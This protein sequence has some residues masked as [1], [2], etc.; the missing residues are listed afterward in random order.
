MKMSQKLFKLLITIF[1]RK[2]NK[3]KMIDAIIGKDYPKKVIP[4]IEAAKNSIKIVV[5][6]WWWYPND[7][8]NPAQIFN[9]S[10]VR[11]VRRGVEVRAIAN[12]NSFVSILNSV[13]I[14]AKKLNIKELVHAK[15]LIIDNNCVVIGSHN[16]NQSAFTVNMEASIIVSDFPQVDEFINFFDSLWHLQN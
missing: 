5:F 10:I 15:L 2:L 1:G 13:G 12:S 7:P 16:F 3:K 8:A 9:Q 14:V 11:A 6:N 4:L